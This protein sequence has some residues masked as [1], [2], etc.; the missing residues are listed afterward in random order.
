MAKSKTADYGGAFA[1][2]L[3]ELLEHHPEHGGKTTYGKLGAVLGVKPQSI[4]Q[5]ANGD[6]TPDMKHIVP[7]AEFFG[8]DCNFLLTGVT[9]ENQT[10]WQDLGL[11]EHSVRHLKDLKALADKKE[12]NSMAMLLITDLFFRSGALL[13]FYDMLNQYVYDRIETNE[14]FEQDKAALEEIDKPGADKVEVLKAVNRL[15]AHETNAEFI[16]YKSAVKVREIMDA[17]IERAGGLEQFNKWVLLNQGR[18][19]VVPEGYEDLGEGE[20]IG[21][22]EIHR[23]D[24]SQPAPPQAE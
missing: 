8:V 19:Q 18:L 21:M 10:I 13:E 12:Q 20:T 24:E 16:W 22:G 5:W 23:V 3:R 2:V 6:T 4:S 15:R 11:H 1:R 9:S 14:I 7:L 17:I